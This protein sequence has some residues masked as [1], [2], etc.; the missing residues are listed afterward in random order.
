VVVPRPFFLQVV[1]FCLYL[2]CVW[3]SVLIVRAIAGEYE[4]CTTRV[5]HLTLALYDVRGLRAIREW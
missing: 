2:A 3:T 5:E 4:A 1:A